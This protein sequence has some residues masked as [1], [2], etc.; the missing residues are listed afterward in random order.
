[1]LSDENGTEWV[2]VAMTS[3]VARLMVICAEDYGFTLH[4]A[5]AKPGTP[6][7]DM[8]A[9]PY[10]RT[11]V[12]KARTE[13]RWLLAAWAWTVIFLALAVARTVVG[14]GPTVGF[15]WWSVLQDYLW[16]ALGVT[17]IFVCRR[18]ARRA[19]AIAARSRKLELD[20]EVEFV[21]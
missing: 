17:V 13:T 10:S 20:M 4:P 11:V 2:R 18:R 9:L 1:M 12:R 3:A 14:V 15:R 5:E 21:D 16:A 19:R 6:E 8:A 7:A